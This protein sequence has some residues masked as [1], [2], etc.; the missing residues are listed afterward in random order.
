MQ[1]VEGWLSGGVVAEM[2]DVGQVYKAQLCRMSSQ[3][4]EVELGDCG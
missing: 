3:K 1:R 2:G 4:S